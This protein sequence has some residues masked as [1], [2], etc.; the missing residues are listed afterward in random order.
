[1]FTTVRPSITSV[2]R[3]SHARTIANSL[4]RHEIDDLLRVGESPALMFREDELVV[5]EHVEHTTAPFLED[6][7][8]TGFCF[9]RGRETRGP[10]QI[11]SS[12]AVLDA[13]LHDSPRG[14][15]VA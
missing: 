11:P 12:D 8:D 3:T 10:L 13:H 4:V 9:D 1:M 7:I 2:G 15:I 14:E 6:W 5:D